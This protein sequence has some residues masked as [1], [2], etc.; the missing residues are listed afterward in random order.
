MNIQESTFFV[1]GGSSGL[2]A[3]VVQHLHRLGAKLVIADLNKTAGEELASQLKGNAHFI[4]TDITDEKNVQAAFEQTVQQF[5]SIQGV[6]NCAGIVLGK[7]ILGKKGVH[8]LNSFMQTLTVNT[9]GTFNVIRFAVEKM[10]TQSPDARGERGIIINTASIAAFDGQVGQ[11]A[12]AASKGAVVSM[13]L[14]LAR[15]LAPLGI[16]VMTIAPGTFATPMLDS[17]PEKVKKSLAAQIPFPSRLGN[18]DEYAALVA[19][20][21]ENQMLNGEVIRL[22]GALRMNTA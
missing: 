6:V 1:T 19:H 3:G 5:G 22:D 7:K 18:P 12:Y 20:I 10:A 4:Y 14:P 8:D 15:E 11:T 13:T 16:R 21:C 2:G 9:T 17:L